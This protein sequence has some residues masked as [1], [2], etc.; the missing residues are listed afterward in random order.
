MDTLNKDT[1]KEL[2]DIIQKNEDAWQGYKKAAEH[3]ESRALM[4]YFSR[5]AEERN[6]FN[7]NLRNTIRGYHKDFD[8]DG[9]IL[10]TVHRG[11]MDLKSLF[12]S[13]NEEAMLEE[14]I[15]GDKAALEE[16]DDVLEE[17]LPIDVRDLLLS[18]RARIS[19]DIRQNTRLE[20]LED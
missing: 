12:S 4:R 19:Q 2:G 20:D 14:S 1:L 11:W 8:T 13:N 10:G 6:A 7:A 3:V 18:Q 16:Y 9:S 5:K 17:A 15:R